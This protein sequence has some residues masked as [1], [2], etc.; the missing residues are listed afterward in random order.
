MSLSAHRYFVEV[1]HV[2]DDVSE[3]VLTGYL[4]TDGTFTVEFDLEAPPGDVWTAADMSHDAVLVVSYDARGNLRTVPDRKHVAAIAERHGY[5]IVRGAR[6]NL[7]PRD[8][9]RLRALPGP[10]AHEKI[11]WNDSGRKLWPYRCVDCRET[12]TPE[13]VVYSNGRLYLAT[14]KRWPHPNMA[15]AAPAVAP[16]NK[17]WRDS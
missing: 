8:F 5:K 7:Q 3:S 2:G 11:D 12:F 9:Q 16:R 17:N 6:V 4:G 14:A 15:A 13:Q 1:R 10:C